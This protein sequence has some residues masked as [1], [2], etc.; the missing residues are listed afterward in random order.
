MSY[1]FKKDNCKLTLHDLDKTLTQTK[2]NRKE[3]RR[4]TLEPSS[5]NVKVEDRNIEKKKTFAPGHSSFENK[6]ST[7]VE[8][9]M[10]KEN[11]KEKEKERG[12]KAT[13]PLLK[14]LFDLGQLGNG[15]IEQIGKITIITYYL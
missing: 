15:T 14:P 3:I 6:L 4:L 12:K 7:A 13:M 11:E 8:Q 1:S 2:F 9:L 5:V 10:E